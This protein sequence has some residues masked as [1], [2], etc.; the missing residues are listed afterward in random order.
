V[1][2]VWARLGV[3]LVLLKLVV[4]PW[5]L[6]SFREGRWWKRSMAGVSSPCPFPYA[7]PLVLLVVDDWWKRQR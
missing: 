5:W 1:V 4:L 3:P 7:F 6:L 2:G